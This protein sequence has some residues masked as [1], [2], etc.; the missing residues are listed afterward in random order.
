MKNKQ[1]H[2]EFNLQS[3]NLQNTQH[4]K[5]QIERDLQSVEDKMKRRDEYISNIEQE[6][7]KLR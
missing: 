6:N 1:L 5:M 7:M 2:E 4:T 3:H